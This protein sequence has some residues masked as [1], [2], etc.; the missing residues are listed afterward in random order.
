M[1]TA[2]QAQLDRLSALPGEPGAQH[3]LAED[4]VAANEAAVAAGPS[5]PLLAV[6]FFDINT[7][8]AAGAFGQLFHTEDGGKRW[9]Y[10]GDRLGNLEGLHLNGLTLTPEG[11]VLIAAEAGTV[12]RSRD[13]GR[14]WA[15]SQ[16]GYKGYLYGV[17]ALPGSVLVAYGFNGHTFRSADGGASWKAIPSRTPK[18]LVAGA[19]RGEH[20]V[21]IDEEGQVLVS[22]D[23]GESF[24]PAGPRLPVRRLSGFALLG[25]DT[26]LT[27]GMGG[28]AVHTMPGQRSKP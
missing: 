16:V 25:S 17:L 2:A 6:K 8:F 12:F 11:D 24:K 10:I 4:A 3:E 19:L 28:A 14:S 23:H 22:T 5:R 1:L 15:R 13:R 27:V 21:L 7:G 18:T 9:R 20:G 26:V